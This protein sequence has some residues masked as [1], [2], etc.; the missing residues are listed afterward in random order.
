MNKYFYKRIFVGTAL[1]A[2]VALLVI[3]SGA[4]SSFAEASP[5]AN[6]AAGMPEAR[7]RAE[8][9]NIRAGEYFSTVKKA[10]SEAKSSI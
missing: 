1:L 2:G 8:V 4:S 3:S 5:A 7:Y 10:L 6:A 9:E